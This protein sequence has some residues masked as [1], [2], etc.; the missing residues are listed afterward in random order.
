M[1]AVGK[2]LSETTATKKI[3]NRTE[4]KVHHLLK[5]ERRGL[6]AIRCKPAVVLIDISQDSKEVKLTRVQNML[7]K[8]EDSSAVT[9][10]VL[11]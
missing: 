7:L 2:P 3:V 4:E 9:L 10:M 8:Q 1:E 6:E 5:H 11:N